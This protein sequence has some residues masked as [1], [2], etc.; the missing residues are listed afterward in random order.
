VRVLAGGESLAPP[1]EAEAT[2]LRRIGAEP[3]VRLACQ[4]RPTEPLTIA[5]LLRPETAPALA[6]GLEGAGVIRVAAVLF[7]DIRGFTALSEAKLAFDIV[8]ILNTFFAEAG[9]AVEAAGGRVDKY[10]GD[11]LMALFEHADGLGPAARNALAAVAAI[12]ASLAKV[13]RRLS[14]EIDAP[15]SLAM[16]LHGGPLVSGRIGYGEAGRPT[17]IGRVVNIASRLET[18]AKARGVELAMSV[19]CAE[20]AG[21][22]LSTVEREAADLRGL[23]GSFPVALLPCVA[24]FAL[25]GDVAA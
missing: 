1:T 17:V 21:L 14:G 23:D 19:A 5:R 10:I 8:Y 9:R 16:G 15:L 6:H 13:N 11:G 12:D 3:G 18:L 24:D 25:A 20:A 2:L 4:I 22:D 7:V